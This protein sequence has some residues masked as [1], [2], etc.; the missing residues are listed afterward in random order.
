MTRRVSTLE[1]IRRLEMV[2]SRSMA[3]GSVIPSPVHPP[4][5]NGEKWTEAQGYTPTAVSEEVFCLYGAG[6]Y[7]GVGI[8]IRPSYETVFRSADIVIGKVGI[9]EP[10]Y[11]RVTRFVN[12]CSDAAGIDRRLPVPSVALMYTHATPLEATLVQLI[13]P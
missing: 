2:P 11:R 1:D 5:L 10:Y 12:R 9:D 7:V 13:A 8:V 4:T 3:P 6:R